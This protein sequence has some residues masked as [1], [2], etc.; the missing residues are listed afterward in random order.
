MGFFLT[1]LGFVFSVLLIITSLALIEHIVSA[2]VMEYE[3]RILAGVWF[4][5][6]AVLTISHL[7]FGISCFRN[8]FF[9]NLFYRGMQLFHFF[10]FI[11]MSIVGAIFSF[12]VMG[13]FE[14]NIVSSLFILFAVI[15]G[16]SFLYLLLPNVKKELKNL[17]SI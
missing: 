2:E 12:P 6:E 17:E 11:V 4:Y 1:G 14:V 8:K 7:Y 10:V 3:D 9:K 5:L 16:A 15:H 13:Y